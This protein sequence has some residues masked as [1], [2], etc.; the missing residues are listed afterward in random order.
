MSASQFTAEAR[1]AYGDRN[2]KIGSPEV[3][4]LVAAGR[5]LAAIDAVKTTWRVITSLATRRVAARL[6]VSPATLYRIVK[7][8]TWVTLPVFANVYLR[9]SGRPGPRKDTRTFPPSLAGALL[10][11]LKRGYEAN[12]E[13][14]SLVAYQ[15]ISPADLRSYFDW[16]PTGPAE[17]AE[18]GHLARLLVAEVAE[19]HRTDPDPRTDWGTVHLAVTGQAAPPP[20]GGGSRRLPSKKI[21][22]MRLAVSRMSPDGFTAAEV[23]AEASKVV[24]QLHQLSQ[25]FVVEDHPSPAPVFSQRSKTNALAE[26]HRRGEVIYS[27]RSGK[28]GYLVGRLRETSGFAGLKDLI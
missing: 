3:L 13:R 9:D 17:T 5:I 6:G 15:R 19:R 28:G 27:Y 12:P 8:E 18:L 25:R 21:D 1:K 22:I 23:K 20:V 11:G 24:N 14:D 2:T 10:S 26:L 16:L 4:D 7:G